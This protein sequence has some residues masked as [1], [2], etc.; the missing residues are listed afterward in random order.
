MIFIIQ[1]QNEIHMFSFWELIN[2]YFDRLSLYYGCFSRFP[3]FYN[4]HTDT[5]LISELQYPFIR[6]L[7]C[8]FNLAGLL[9][10]NYE[11]TIMRVKNTVFPYNI[12]TKLHFKKHWNNIDYK[13]ACMN[14]LTLYVPSSLNCWCLMPFSAIFQLFHG[15]QF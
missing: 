10:V 14:L 9:Q 4:L 6:V 11:L 1:I 13:I 12:N 15:D 7:E 5:Y 2:D 8:K 3:W